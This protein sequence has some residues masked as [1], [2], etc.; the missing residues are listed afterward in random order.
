MEINRE[1]TDYTG[2]EGVNRLWWQWGMVSWVFVLF[3]LKS[4][5]LVLVCR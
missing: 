5:N 1:N 2:L 4:E 3:S